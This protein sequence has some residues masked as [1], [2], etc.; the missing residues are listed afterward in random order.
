MFHFFT[1]REN[2][3][4]RRDSVS[5]SSGIACTNS[6]P[7]AARSAQDRLRVT[8]EKPAITASSPA[9][10]GHTTAQN[11]RIVPVASR[12]CTEYLPTCAAS[13][14]R[15]CAKPGREVYHQSVSSQLSAGARRVATSTPCGP[16]TS[17]SS[18]S[19]S[20]ATLFDQMPTRSPAASV[21]SKGDPIGCVRASRTD[22]GW[23]CVAA[24]WAASWSF[25]QPTDRLPR[26]VRQP[27]MP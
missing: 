1:F 10:S 17:H 4:S 26:G 25:R 6:Q 19:R 8:A 13:K 2:T 20:A 16:V 18:T 14:A 7:A 15:S 27:A 11:A 21:A 9:S 23:P 5:V 24:G 3:R 12:Q 22:A